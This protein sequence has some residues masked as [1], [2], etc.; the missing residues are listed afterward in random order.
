MK[1]RIITYRCRI[2]G[3][4]YEQNERTN[5]EDVLEEHL[6]QI[7]FFQHERLV[8]LIVTMT[9]ALLTIMSLAIGILGEFLTGYLLTGMFTILLVPY[10]FHYYT[11]ENEVQKMYEQYDEILKLVRKE[12]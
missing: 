8:H 10:I 4:L 2:D 11:L 9:V 6:T 7:G 12:D 5:W 1:R 3:L